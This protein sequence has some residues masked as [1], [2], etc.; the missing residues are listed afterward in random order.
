MLASPA[1]D[2]VARFVGTDRGLKRLSLF[3]VAELPLSQIVTAPVGA[4]GAIAR[5][6]AHEQ[7]FDHVLIVGRRSSGRSAG[8]T[9]TG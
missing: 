8:C 3:R 6:V 4:D 2:F 5:R 9:A 7:P 1:S